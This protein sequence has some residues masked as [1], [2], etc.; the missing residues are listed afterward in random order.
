MQGFKRILL[1]V[2]VIAVI[3]IGLAMIITILDSDDLR[4]DAGQVS[5]QLSQDDNLKPEGAADSYFT[6]P[7]EPVAEPD[8]APAS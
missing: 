6:Q 3:L 5:P 4:Q 1:A 7:A 8:P 2:L